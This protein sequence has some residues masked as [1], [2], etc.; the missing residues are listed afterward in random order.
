V[1]G[2]RINPPDAPNEKFY[3]TSNYT[4]NLDGKVNPPEGSKIPE[5]LTKLHEW[6][7]GPEAH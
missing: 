6:E 5:L 2:G 3:G 7:H 1:I 4:D